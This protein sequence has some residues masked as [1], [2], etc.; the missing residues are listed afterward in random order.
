MQS[1]NSAPVEEVGGVKDDGPWP[2]EVEELAVDDRLQ[3]PVQLGDG[4]V[5]ELE[6][7]VTDIQQFV[8]DDGTATDGYAVS[9][10][11]DDP[12]AGGAL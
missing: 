11:Y 9:Y 10:Q 2:S 3:R 5:T 1:V 4:T 7:T 6:V 8:R 12:N